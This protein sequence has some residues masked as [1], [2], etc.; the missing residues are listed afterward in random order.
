M[1]NIELIMEV[2][3]SLSEVLFNFCMKGKSCLDDWTNE[4]LD[5]SLEFREVFV[6]EGAVDSQERGLLREGD[7]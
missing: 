1:S 5:G 2:S 6:E 4:F 7:C 3:S